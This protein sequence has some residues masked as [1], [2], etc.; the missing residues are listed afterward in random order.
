MLP[1]GIGVTAFA[2]PRTATNASEPLRRCARYL[3][4]FFACGGAAAAQRGA[5]LEFARLQRAMSLPWFLEQCDARDGLARTRTPEALQSLLSE[6]RRPS[7]HREHVRATIA[8]LLGRYF[9]EPRW[10]APLDELRATH[11]NEGGY[12]LQAQLLSG[13]LRESRPSEIIERIHAAQTAHAAAAIVTALS[14]RAPKLLHESVPGLLLRLPRGTRTRDLLLGA[15][16]CGML[17]NRGRLDA[18]PYRSAWDAWA[19]LLGEER[20]THQPHRHLV[21]RALQVRLDTWHDDEEPGFWR[22]LLGQA[23]RGDSPKGVTRSRPSFF[24]LESDGRRVAFLIDVSNSMAQRFEH[25]RES[26]GHTGAAHW[27]SPRLGE[28]DLPWSLIENR[29]ELARA[30]LGLALRRLDPELRFTVILFG[31]K[32]WTLQCTRGFVPASDENVR[33]AIDELA[34]I[35]PTQTTQLGHAAAPVFHGGTNLHGALRLAFELLPW[36]KRARNCWTDRRCLEGGCDTIFVLSDGVPSLDDFSR[37]GGLAEAFAG[38]PAFA[39][40][41]A[42][43]QVYYRG[44]YTREDW[45]LEDLRRLN[46][47]RMVRIHCVGIGEAQM[48]LLE[49]LSGDNFGKALR[50][51]ARR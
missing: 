5:E 23:E 18:E 7:G 12:W 32:A 37:R 44:P 27:R 17:R 36:G 3:L 8:T 1:L 11:T 40:K 2:P 41:G 46:A 51:R 15:T 13:V 20:L 28:E 39:G 34:E 24:G 49:A 48:S 21:V 42:G 6:Y 35:E 22:H 25:G 16:A 33:A 50:Y 45:L 14:L 29:Y 47:L 10:R 38:H 4:L 43:A 31:G 30:H 19:G 9:G 26:P